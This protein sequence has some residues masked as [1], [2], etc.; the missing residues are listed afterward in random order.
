[1][2]LELQASSSE[3]RPHGKRKGKSGATK[4]QMHNQ[5]KKYGHKSVHTVRTKRVVKKVYPQSI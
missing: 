3:M 2:T 4:R 1:M 5:D